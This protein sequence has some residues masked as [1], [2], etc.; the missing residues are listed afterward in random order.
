MSSVMFQ[1]QGGDIYKH[2]GRKFELKTKIS[3]IEPGNL[4]FIHPKDR[5]RLSVA[6]EVSRVGSRAEQFFLFLSFFKLFLMPAFSVEA[7]PADPALR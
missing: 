3:F 5:D 2:L 1:L 6:S 7:S 4:Y